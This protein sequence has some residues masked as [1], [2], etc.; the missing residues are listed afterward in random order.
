[1]TGEAWL[2][3]EWSSDYL[4]SGAVGWDWIGIDLERGGALMAFR[5]RGRDGN[6]RWAGGTLREPDGHVQS[7]G[8]EDVTFTPGRV[9]HS[10]RT[11]ID[12]PVTWSIRA[13][14][15]RLTLEPLMDDQESDARLSTGAI[16]W[17]GAVRALEGSTPVGRGYLELTGY[18]DPLELK[19]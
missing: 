1:V 3:H 8:P 2:D 13:G 4:E 14:A 15:R 11:G 19:Y 9:W 6:T 18:G 17:E 5:I 10:A 7:L 12:Y 16:Y